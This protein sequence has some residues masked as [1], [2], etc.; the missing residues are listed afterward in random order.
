MI[1]CSTAC[2]GH[3]RS[4]F[5]LSCFSFPDLCNIP[6]YSYNAFVSYKDIDPSI[7]SFIELDI[8]IH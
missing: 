4:D 8:I 3:I 1:K 6:V 2:I 7:L 5:V